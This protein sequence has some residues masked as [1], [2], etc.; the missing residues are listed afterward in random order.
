M[1][2]DDFRWLAEREQRAQDAASDLM[3]RR[4]EIAKTLTRPIIGI[5]LRTPEEVFDIMVDRI[6]RALMLPPKDPTP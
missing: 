2:E 5:E 1:S 6:T 3:A 4:R